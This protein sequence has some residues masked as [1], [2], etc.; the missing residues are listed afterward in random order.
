MLLKHLKEFHSLLP[1]PGRFDGVRRRRKILGLGR[2]TAT[3]SKARAF[4]QKML[5]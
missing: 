5:L 2:W 4:N 1:R 3:A